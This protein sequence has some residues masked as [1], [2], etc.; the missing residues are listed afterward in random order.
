MPG[1]WFFIDAIPGRLIRFYKKDGEETTDTYVAAR[2]LDHCKNVR[3]ELTSFN[4]TVRNDGLSKII[5]HYKRGV[6]VW[7]QSRRK[8]HLVNA[9][10]DMKIIPAMNTELILE[11]GDKE[12]T[13]DVFECIFEK[14]ERVKKWISDGKNVKL[15]YYIE[16][17]PSVTK[18]T[19]PGI[20]SIN[21]DDLIVENNKGYKLF[22]TGVW[23]QNSQRQMP[24]GV[25]ASKRKVTIIGF[26]NCIFMLILLSIL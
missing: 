9:R 7:L 3:V 22:I 16:G 13:L 14:F 15:V 25:F 21:A 23:C 8:Y 5:V 24:L 12:I 17:R 10:S 11:D 6:E 1:D 19:V 4:G 26:K 18:C 2:W 20:T